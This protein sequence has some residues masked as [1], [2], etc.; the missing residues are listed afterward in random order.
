MALTATTDRPDL[1]P[2]FA[3]NPVRPLYRPADVAK[4]LACS[5]WWVKEQAR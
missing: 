3:T 4:L 1:N 5:E 2:R